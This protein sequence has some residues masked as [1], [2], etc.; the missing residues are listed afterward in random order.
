MKD[1][2]A[3]GI[4]SNTQKKQEGV[5][6]VRQKLAE[7]EAV[8]AYKRAAQLEF[9]QQYG[10]QGRQVTHPSPAHV[11]RMRHWLDSGDAILVAEAQVFFDLMQ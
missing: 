1:S 6:F 8:Q 9:W 10:Q 4:S 5:E 11:D 3:E 7:V 2:N